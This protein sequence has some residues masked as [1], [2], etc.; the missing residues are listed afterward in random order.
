[1][2]L[3]SVGKLA[4]VSVSGATLLLMSELFF[5]FHFAW[6]IKNRLSDKKQ[7]AFSCLSYSYELCFSFTILAQL[8]ALEK[9]GAE[10]AHILWLSNAG[11]LN[12]M[13]SNFNLQTNRC[14]GKNQLNFDHKCSFYSK[15]HFWKIKSEN[16]YAFNVSI[17]LCCYEDFI[18]FALQAFRILL[19]AI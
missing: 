15:I 1:M 11:E 13:P 16:L 17:Q 10:E 19:F 5:F 9:T 4:C 6:P 18:W 2:W 7:N 12:F 14:G 8:D 3:P